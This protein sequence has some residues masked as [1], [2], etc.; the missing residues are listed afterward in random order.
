MRNMGNDKLKVIG[1]VY[2]GLAAACGAM[3]VILSK[4]IINGIGTLSPS[5]LAICA[6]FTTVVTCAALFGAAVARDCFTLARTR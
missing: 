4:A 5:S 3:A 6:T 1:T 2:G